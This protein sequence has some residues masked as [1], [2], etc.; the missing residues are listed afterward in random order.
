[1]NL[2]ELSDAY[3][4]ER[5]TRVSKVTYDRDVKMSELFFSSH[6][7]REVEEFLTEDMMEKVCVRVTLACEDAWK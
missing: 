4:I 3:F 7:K 1:M 2:K 5:K 6:Y